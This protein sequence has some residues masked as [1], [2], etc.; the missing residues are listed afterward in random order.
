M[1]GQPP[2]AVR[3][4]KLDFFRAFPELAPSYKNHK[5]GLVGPAFP[6]WNWFVGHCW[7][8]KPECLNLGCRRVFCSVDCAISHS[9]LRI[10]VQRF[11]LES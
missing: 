3:R 1:W 11:Q 8:G 2:S 4:A 9:K 5:A 10:Q 7:I 6:L